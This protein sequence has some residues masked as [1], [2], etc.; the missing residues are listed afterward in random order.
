MAAQT[1]TVSVES[2]TLVHIKGLPFR[3]AA[4]AKVTGHPANFQL[5]ELPMADDHPSRFDLRELP[6]PDTAA[7]K[8]I[9]WGQKLAENLDAEAV[10]FRDYEQLSPEHWVVARILT[11]ITAAITAA[12]GDTDT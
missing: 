10:K 7:D 5:L 1:Q 2:G 4:D 8:P 6:F 12:N 11:S 9:S 3:L